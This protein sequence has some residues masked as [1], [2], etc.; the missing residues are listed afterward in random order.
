MIILTGRFSREDPSRAEK[1]NQQE[2][3]LS[4]YDLIHVVSGMTS[5]DQY[6][7]IKYTAVCDTIVTLP[8]VHVFQPYPT[9]VMEAS[10]LLSDCSNR[11]TSTADSQPASNNL[12]F[13]LCKHRNN[14][15]LY[16]TKNVCYM[17]L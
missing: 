17:W 7:P 11:V 3:P 15:L 8:Y 5:L 13:Y 9:L 4:W 12:L 1:S 14:W 6:K 10:Q 16:V 2:Q